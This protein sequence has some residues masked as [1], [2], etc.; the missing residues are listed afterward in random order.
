MPKRTRSHEAWLLKTLTDPVV[1]ANYVNAALDDSFEMF[2]TAIRNVAEAHTMGKVAEHARLN[3][4]NLYRSLSKRGN[5]R[6]DTLRAVLSA[7]GLRL[8]VEP[9]NSNTPIMQALPIREQTRLKC[10]ELDHLEGLVYL[11]SEVPRANW[12]T[13]SAISWQPQVKIMQMVSEQI[14]GVDVAGRAAES[15]SPAND[16]SN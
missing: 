10:Q 8:S 12:L 7:V 4:E 14:A 1:A 16:Y 11:E 13:G 6:L 2:L 15:Q 9:D 5:P 3:R